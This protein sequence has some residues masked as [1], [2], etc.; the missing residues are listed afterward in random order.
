[1]LFTR[2]EGSM[3]LAGRWILAMALGLLAIG[4]TGQRGTRGEV[5]RIRE[6]ERKIKPFMPAALNDTTRRHLVYPFRIVGDSLQF[7][8]SAVSLRPGRMPYHPRGAGNFTVTFLN[9][10]GVRLD[11]YSM[12]DPR[13]VRSCDLSEGRHGE[14][15][16]LSS[17]VVEILAPADR[18]IAFVV[19]SSAGGREQRI[20]VNV[21]VS[22]APPA[23][24]LKTTGP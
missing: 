20:P 24:I 19:L 4:C 14:V 18:A 3:R 6:V 23:G 10:A 16:F 12:E 11:G 1:M 17:G 21:K 9:S 7:L 13:T 5:S 22:R 8:P 15:A 2:D